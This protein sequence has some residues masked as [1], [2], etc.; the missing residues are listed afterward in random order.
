MLRRNR[1]KAVINEQPPQKP[2]TTNKTKYMTKANEIVKP[3]VLLSLLVGYIPSHFRIRGITGGLLWL[4]SLVVHGAFDFLSARKCY[5]YAWAS[6]QILLF[7]NLVMCT[8][9]I[10]GIGVPWLECGLGQLEKENK[11]LKTFARIRKLFRVI[12]ITNFFILELKTQM[13]TKSSFFLLKL[14][15]Y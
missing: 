12:I 2:L 8:Y 13:S 9:S 10:K 3:I 14:L 6:I 5:G 15:L 7:I 11:Y 1:G 4:I